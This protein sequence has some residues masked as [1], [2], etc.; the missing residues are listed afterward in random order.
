MSNDIWGTCVCMRVWIALSRLG[1]SDGWA[2][3]A[4]VW[5]YGPGIFERVGGDIVSGGMR[6][7]RLGRCGCRRGR[8][9]IGR[10]GGVVLVRVVSWWGGVSGAGS[11]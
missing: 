4:W 3:I 5:G 11:V 2:C 1:L 6:V 10:G 8:G 7:N 9:W